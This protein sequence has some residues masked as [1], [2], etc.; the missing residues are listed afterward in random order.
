MAGDAPTTE[1]DEIVQVRACLPRA[2]VATKEPIMGRLI[3][4]A[5]AVLIFACEPSTALTLTTEE[6]PPFNMLDERTKEPT[7]ITVDKVVELMRRAHEPITITSYPWPRAYQM[8]LKT[9][10]TCVFSTSRTSEREALFAWIGPLAKSDWAIFARANDA[11][12]PKTLED[13]RPFV[14]GGYTNAATGEYLKLHGFKVDLVSSDALNLQKLLR[15][16]IDFWATGDLLG[17]YL[18]RKAGLTD[19]IVPLFKFELSELYLA[20]NLSMNP[21]RVAKFNEIL[22][23]MARDGSSAAIDRKYR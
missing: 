22:K 3:L 11:R 2:V 16:R 7:G 14:I 23:E 4:A 6:Y 9:E 10:N 17:R 1:Y 19:Q 13:V 18:I 8:A 15:S 12:K 20:C 5:A 21:R